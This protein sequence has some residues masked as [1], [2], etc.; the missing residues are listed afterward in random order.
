MTSESIR[1]EIGSREVATVTLAR[2]E[3]H[4]AMDAVMIADLTAAA[5]HLAM[6]DGVRVVVLQAEG[7]TFCADVLTRAGGVARSSHRRSWSEPSK[8]R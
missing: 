1:I 6:D 5:E 4:N 7:R 3:K 8:V 2:A